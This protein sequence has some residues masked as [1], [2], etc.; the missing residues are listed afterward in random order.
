MKNRTKL[1]ISLFLFTTLAYQGCGG[2]G[3]Q[4]SA[5]A[6]STVTFEYLVLNTGCQTL[7]CPRVDRVTRTANSQGIINYSP[8]ED[9][10]CYPSQ[11]LTIVGRGFN[12]FGFSSAQSVNLQSYP[13][14]LTFHTGAGLHS[15]YG[16]PLVQ[17]TDTQGV[18]VQAQVATDM[19]SDG[20]W[21]TI[22]MPN[23][24]G[25]YSGNYEVVI[26]NRRGDGAYEQVGLAYLP[27]YGNDPVDSDGDGYYDY[28]DCAPWDP[29]L[30]Y[31]CTVYDPCGQT[32]L[33]DGGLEP[34]RPIDPIDPCLQY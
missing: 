21:V 12:P 10:Q 15:W 31:D 8:D 26:S 22:N 3:C 6:G 1:L 25:G 30:N 29:L 11:K 17:I 14:S 27:T 5:P 4:L 24:A 16:M 33:K 32:G 18:S 13:S 2:S 28:Q 9:G 19:G 23:M 34:L 20:S 7:R